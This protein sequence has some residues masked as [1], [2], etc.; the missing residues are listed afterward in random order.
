MPPVSK[1]RVSVS[2]MSTGQ[3]EH[4]RWLPMPLL[5][6]HRTNHAPEAGLDSSSR[7][8]CEQHRVIRRSIAVLCGCDATPIANAGVFDTGGSCGWGGSP[9]G[10]GTGRSRVTGG[11]R[12]RQRWQR[13]WFGFG[14]EGCS[15]ADWAMPRRDRGPCLHQAGSAVARVKPAAF[16][17]IWCGSHGAG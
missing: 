14:R 8:R 17:L 11:T 1:P 2:I 7:P 9:G 16:H 12:C 3:G 10:R 5:P 4:G 15:V 6:R 13:G